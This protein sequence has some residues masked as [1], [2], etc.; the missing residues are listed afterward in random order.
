MNIFIDAQCKNMIAMVNTFVQ[1]CEMAS[2]KDD[3]SISK[4]EEKTLKRI[5]TAAEKFK[6]E[7]AKAQ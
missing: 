2:Q 3:G 5:K 4:D 7:I 1:A 6:A